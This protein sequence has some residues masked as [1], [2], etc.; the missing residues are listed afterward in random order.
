MLSIH[1]IIG[2]ERKHIVEEEKLNLDMLTRI[3]FS[4]AATSF[5]SMFND[6]IDVINTK[7]RLMRGK[8]TIVENISDGELT[9]VSSEIEGD[10]KGVGHLVLNSYEYQLMAKSSNPGS[11]SSFSISPQSIANSGIENIIM[12]LS[13]AFMNEFKDF[14]KVEVKYRQPVVYRTNA[15]GGT[16]YINR[17]KGAESTSFVAETRFVF[18]SHVEAR[19][20][21]V[22]AF[23]G[24]I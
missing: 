24:M 8:E 4:N 14:L 9:I 7:V 21:F 3:G 18:H 19:P 13:K 1:N 22:M 17:F 10:I 12:V 23:Q 5:S 11:R 6:V 16:Q 15:L 20:R 2:V